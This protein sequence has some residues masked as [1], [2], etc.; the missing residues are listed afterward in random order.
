ML[1]AS[2]KRDALQS[3]QCL[4]QRLPKSGPDVYMQLA[5]LC[6]DFFLEN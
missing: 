3:E 1:A 4:S 5:L 6:E 2:D